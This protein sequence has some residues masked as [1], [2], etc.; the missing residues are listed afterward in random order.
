MAKKRPEPPPPTVPPCMLFCDGVILEHG[1]GKT[2]LVGTFSGVIA[3]SFPSPPKDLHVYV[4][5]TSFEGAIPVQLTCV[6]V[7]QAEPEEIYSTTHL[8]SFRGKL[9]VEQLHLVWNQFQFPGPGEYAFQVWS[10]SRCIAE[11]RL[12]VRVKGDVA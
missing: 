7:D 10:Q 11:R 1:T 6:R 4:Q 8:V 12:T 2:T 3:P 9:I 5:L